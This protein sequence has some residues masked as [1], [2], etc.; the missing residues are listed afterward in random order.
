MLGSR[1]PPRS[2]CVGSVTASHLIADVHKATLRGL[3]RP[4]R[5]WPYAYDN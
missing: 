4:P 1:H 3:E 2:L 5:H